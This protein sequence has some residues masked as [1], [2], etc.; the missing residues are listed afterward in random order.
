M[1]PVGPMAVNVFGDGHRACVARLRNA[2]HEL[3]DAQRCD[4]GEP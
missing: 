3:S 4:S 2:S 1:T